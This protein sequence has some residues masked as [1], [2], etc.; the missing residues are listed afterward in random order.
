[1]LEKH[2]KIL[3]LYNRSVFLTQHLD[4]MEEE[5]MQALVEGR[6]WDGPEPEPEES[7]D[8]QSRGRGQGPSSSNSPH[9]SWSNSGGR[10]NSGGKKNKK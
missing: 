8:H 10:S 7:R 9:Q 3:P 6:E 5:R 4:L 2:S 1:M